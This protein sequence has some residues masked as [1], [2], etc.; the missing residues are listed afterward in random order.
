MPTIPGP[1]DE[2]G[3]ITVPAEGGVEIPLKEQTSD[4]TP[5]QVDISALPLRFYVKGRLDIVPDVDPEDPLGRLL[6]ITEDEADNLGTSPVS[7]QLLDET[8]PDVPIPL[9][10]GTIRRGQ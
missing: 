1:V 2:S 3:N 10:Y 5:V 9:W 8:N 6:T 7:F 4:T